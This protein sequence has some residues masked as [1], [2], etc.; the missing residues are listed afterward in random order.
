MWVKGGDGEGEVW[1]VGVE[2]NYETAIWDGGDVGGLGV[3]EQWQLARWEDGEDFRSTSLMVNLFR[4]RIV[5]K[6]FPCFEVL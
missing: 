2:W 4:D 1:W 6:S 3:V 5:I